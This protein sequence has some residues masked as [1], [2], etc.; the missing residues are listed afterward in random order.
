MDNAEKILVII[1]ASALAVFLVIGIIALIKFVQILDHIK[2][3]TQKA[4]HIAE[5]AEAVGAF[6]QKTAGPIALGKLLSNISEHIFGGR[7]AKKTKRS[8]S[9]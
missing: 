6:F 1:L 4:E 8:K 2:T 5:Q 3:I 7:E 9:A